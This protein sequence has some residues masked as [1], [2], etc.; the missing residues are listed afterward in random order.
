MNTTKTVTGPETTMS[1]VC[2]EMENINGTLLFRYM[3]NVS[4]VDEYQQEISFDAN[5]DPPAWFVSIMSY[6]QEF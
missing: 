4:F 5:G 1:P 2:P 6:K 3:V